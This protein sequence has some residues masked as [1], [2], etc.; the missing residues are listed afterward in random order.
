M[1]C[2]AYSCVWCRRVLILP[3]LA[4]PNVCV[5][6][7]LFPFS[8]IY[9]LG[10]AVVASLFSIYMALYS[11]VMTNVNNSKKLPFLLSMEK[12]YLLHRATPYSQANIHAAM[13]YCLVLV[14]VEIA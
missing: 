3:K 4:D 13:P 12:A 11:I 2:N 10:H 5:F 9:L 6:V 1:Q 7:F 14:Y 8:N